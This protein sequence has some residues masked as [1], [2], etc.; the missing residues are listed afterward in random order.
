[1]H[2]VPFVRRQLLCSASSR[3]WH[4]NLPCTFLPSDVLH[5]V[6]VL[7][8]PPLVNTEREVPDLSATNA[9]PLLRSGSSASNGNHRWISSKC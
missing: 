9:Y 5:D 4:R 6:S 8:H 7:R 2:H 1:M 3:I